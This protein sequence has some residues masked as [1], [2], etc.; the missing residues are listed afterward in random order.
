M[1]P[2]RAGLP[3]FFP[4]SAALLLT[5]CVAKDPGLLGD[6]ETGDAPT[7][8]DSSDPSGGTDG[9]ETCSD[10]ARSYYE[11]LAKPSCADPG[12]P[13]LSEAG[14]YEPCNTQDGLCTVGVCTQVQTQDHCGSAECCVL[15]TEL[16]LGDAPD[17][18]CNA[19][20]GTTFA[21]VEEILCSHD[22]EDPSFCHAWVELAEDGTVLWMD[23]DFGQGG[24]YTCEGG[25]LTLDP[26]FELDHSFDL[27]T[28]ILTWDGREYVPDTVCEQIVGT[29]FLSVE[30]LECGLGEEGPV[31]CNWEI[32]FE[33]D[34]DYLWMYSDVGE[35][36]T[37]SCQGG[38]LVISGESDLDF[39]AA[40]GILTWDGVEYVA[41][42]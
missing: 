37:Y 11:P 26:S 32:T 28:G 21:S 27:A 36:G 12:V 7:S 29:T 30:Q 17:S 14:C 40:T 18:V 6:L 31:L 22:E 24:T 4:F 16:C 23:G 33:A 13:L 34:G 35:G 38:N 42:P 19:L 5:A 8:G 3:L 15:I 41:A 39:D 1:N 2:L 20:V 9:D 10:P 25:V